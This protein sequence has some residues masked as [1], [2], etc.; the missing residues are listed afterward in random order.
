MRGITGD[1]LE[2]GWNVCAKRLSFAEA[3][4]LY[5][6]VSEMNAKGYNNWGIDSD[7]FCDL[8][9]WLSGL[10]GGKCN[11]LIDEVN[12]IMKGKEAANV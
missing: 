2:A 5:Q 7:D 12:D 9:A 4:S 10:I 8:T 1:R 6:I 3:C 11:E